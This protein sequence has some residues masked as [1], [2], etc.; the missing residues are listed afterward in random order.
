MLCTK[1]MLDERRTMIRA[2]MQDDAAAVGR[3]AI[4]SGLFPEDASSFLDKMMADY[5]GGNMA[6][7][8]RCV[9]VEEN[10]QLLGVAYYEP[11]PATDRTWYLTMIAV[12][13]DVQGRGLGA[14]LMRHVESDLQ[15]DGQRILFVETSGLPEFALTRQ[16]YHKCG[17]EEEA[18]VR[19]YF[20][21]GDDMILFRKALNIG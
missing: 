13:G 2:I 12:R 21:V 16:F 7:G 6:D 14:A 1:N 15:A 17:Y 20:T 11:A 19:D 4:A 5:F 8:H 10:G 18:R 3:L 9:V